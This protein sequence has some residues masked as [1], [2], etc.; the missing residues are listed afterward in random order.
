MFMLDVLL[1]IPVDTVAGAMPEF[2]NVGVAEVVEP[3]SLWDLA[4]KGGWIMIV[5]LILSLIATYIFVERLLLYRSVG[6]SDPT[7]LSKIRD[8]IREERYNLL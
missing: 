2:S 5:L 6:K 8:Y 1:Q 7:F 3:M 4:V